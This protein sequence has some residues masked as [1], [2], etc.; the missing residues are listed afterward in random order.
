MGQYYRDIKISAQEKI[1]YCEMKL[2]RTWC[3]E[4]CSELVDQRMQVKLQWMQNTSEVNEDNLSNVRRESSRHFRK[5]EREYLQEKHN[6]LES[7]SK[8]RK[9]RGLYRRI[10]KFQKVYQPRN[11]FVKDERGDLLADPRKILNM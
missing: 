1:G 8:N 2:H 10:N 6:E 4:K 5:K 9:I 11:K 3:D 7:E